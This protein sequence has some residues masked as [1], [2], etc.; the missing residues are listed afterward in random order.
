MRALVIAVVLSLVA[1][2]GAFAGEM[3]DKM[4]RVGR[5]GWKRPMRRYL[6]IFLILLLFGCFARVGTDFDLKKA[7]QITNGMARNEVVELIGNKAT[8]ES[9]HFINGKKMTV[10]QW[11]FGQTVGLKTTAKALIVSFDENDRVVNFS[12]GQSN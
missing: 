8:H 7:N 3:C 10:L 6:P 5:L 2:G 1:S 11:S 4:R 9:V 12:T